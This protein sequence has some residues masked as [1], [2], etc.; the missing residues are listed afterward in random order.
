VGFFV[1]GISP[2]RHGGLGEKEN[3]EVTKASVSPDALAWGSSC[4][5]FHHGGTEVTEKIE[6]TNPTNGTNRISLPGGHAKV[7]RDFNP[8]KRG[9]QIPLPVRWSQTRRGEEGLGEGCIPGGP[10]EVWVR[11][12]RGFCWRTEFSYHLPLT[13][14][15]S[16]AFVALDSRLS[17]LDSSVTVASSR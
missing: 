3:H 13:T 14:H 11:S 17:A 4:L 1:L 16:L 2:R 6:T 8:W 9:S 12:T 7:A 15:H 10:D 5:G